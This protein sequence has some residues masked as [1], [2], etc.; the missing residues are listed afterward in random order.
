M[1]ARKLTCLCF[2]N[3]P[4]AQKRFFSTRKLSNAEVRRK[5]NDLFEAEKQRQLSLY[6]RIEKVEVQY[7]GLPESCTLIMNKGISTPYNCAMHMT[8]HIGNQAVLALV[9]GKLWDMH[10][11]LMED[12]QLS[13]LHFRDED[14][15]MVNKAFWRSCSFILGGVLETAFKEEFY[16]QLCS[17]PKPDVRSGS[18]VYDVDL[19]MSH[20]SPSSVELRC[21]SQI[22]SRLKEKDYKF[23]RLDMTIEKAEEMFTDNKYKLQQIPSIASKSESLNHVTVYRAGEHIDISRGPMIS[24]TALLNRFDISA[25]H[26]LDTSLSNTMYRVQ[27]IGMPTQ[28]QL[29]Y[30]TY[31]QLVNRSKKLNPALM[32]G[33][34]TQTDILESTE[35]AKQQAVD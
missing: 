24:T 20:W 17:F 11:P 31:E 14:P 4:I 18:F 30:W 32:P 25:V 29:H 28:L 7:T 23:E 22:G 9:N 26:K 27:G 21:I 33:T 15:R 1:H 12:C 10:R 3:F 2:R 8:E 19:D 6:E 16:I 5:R 34:E 35:P 13:F